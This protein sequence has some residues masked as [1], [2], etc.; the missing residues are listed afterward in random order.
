MASLMERSALAGLATVGH[1]GR[2]GTSGLYSFGDDVSLLKEHAWYKDNSKGYDPPVGQKRAN[3]WGLY[4]MHGYVFGWCLDG[5]HPNYDG[6][7]ADGSAWQSADSSDRVIRGG[8]WSDSADASR[9]AWR[10]RRPIETRSDAIGFRCV[11]VGTWPK[12]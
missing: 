5:W 12:R 6:A 3:P 1:F 8:A 11:K 9:S 4:D 10:G 7:P 2:A